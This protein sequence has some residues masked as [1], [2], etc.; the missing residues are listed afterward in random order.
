VIQEGVTIADAEALIFR[1]EP[2]NSLMSD[3]ANALRLQTSTLHKGQQ[4]DSSSA[5][6]ACFPHANTSSRWVDVDEGGSTVA[7]VA[8]SLIGSP[9]SPSSRQPG[10]RKATAVVMGHDAIIAATK[11]ETHHAPLLHHR[12]IYSTDDVCTAAPTTNTLTRTRGQLLTHRTAS[13]LLDGVGDALSLLSLA[14]A[15]VAPTAGLWRW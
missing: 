2:M 8:F 4:D 12:R 11:H 6:S 15:W 10:A 1:S 3:P 14:V 13:A 9:F 5:N 7:A